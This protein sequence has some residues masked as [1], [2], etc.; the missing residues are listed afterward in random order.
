M[1]TLE[2]F[3]YVVG[4]GGFICTVLWLLGRK[5]IRRSWLA[6]AVFCFFVAASITPTAVKVLWSWSVIPA[7]AWAPITFCGDKTWIY[8]FVFG[9]L[10]ILVVAGVVFWIW[11]AVCSKR[12]HVV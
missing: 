7:I 6:R 3:F 10:P 9:L 2:P 12:D 8:G 4:I 5:L 1:D 11:T